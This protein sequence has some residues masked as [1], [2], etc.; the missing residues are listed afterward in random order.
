MDFKIETDGLAGAMTFEKADNIMNNVFLSLMIPRGGWW[1]N[2]QFGSRLHLLQRAKNTERTAI[3]AREYVKE[4]LAWLIAARR[5]VKI[6]VA[7]ERDP[8]TDPH[9]L[10]AL[11]EVTQADGR[12]LTFETFVEV[13]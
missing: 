13:V 4:A 10:K 3:L 11:I 1:F 5:A 9:R 2:P 8:R 12:E 6:D 7:T